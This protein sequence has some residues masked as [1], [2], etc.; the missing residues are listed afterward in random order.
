MKIEEFASGDVLVV[1]IATESAARDHSV[2]PRP[3][4]TIDY[5]SAGIPIKI[6]AIGPEVARFKEMLRQAALKDIEDLTKNKPAY[7]APARED[8]DWEDDLPKPDDVVGHTWCEDCQMMV[9]NNMLD[10]RSDRRPDVHLP[11]TS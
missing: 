11:T 10:H 9:P 1:T 4:I 5:D 8:N 6:T 2:Y 3:L 7:V